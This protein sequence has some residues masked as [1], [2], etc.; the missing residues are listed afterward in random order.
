MKSLSATVL[1]MA[2][3]AALCAGCATPRSPQPIAF[4]AVK[5]PTGVI[6]TAEHIVVREEFPR[7]GFYAVN[8]NFRPAPDIVSYVEQ[9]SQLAGTDILRNVDVQL[10][11]PFYIDILFCGY[12]KATDIATAEGK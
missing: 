7:G 1:S 3:I 11:V 2:L 4:L 8:C 9:I 5:R 10:V 6:R 12:N